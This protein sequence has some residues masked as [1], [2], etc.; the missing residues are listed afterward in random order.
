MPEGMGREGS[1]VYCNTVRVTFHT[2]S[3][4][5]PSRAARLSSAS[6][7]TASASASVSFSHAFF[8]T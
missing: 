3:L 7:S 5:P 6:R 1:F 8:C 2:T 4:A